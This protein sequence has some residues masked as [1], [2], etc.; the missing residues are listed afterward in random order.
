MT[1]TDDLT[2]I[3]SRLYNPN[4]PSTFPNMRTVLN[5]TLYMLLLVDLSGRGA[6]IARH[7]LRPEHMCLRWEDVTF[8]TF[9]SHDDDDFA[10]QA[11]IKVRWAKGQS[12]N[13]SQF[14]II[15]LP[16]LFPSSFCLQDTLQMLIAQ[17]HRA[18][19]Q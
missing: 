12:L 7:H 6:D 14:R 10:I 1:H 18:V 8:F 2:L 3:I 5:L 16:A 13:E 17:E 11:Q 9:R 19:L 4:Y 15:P